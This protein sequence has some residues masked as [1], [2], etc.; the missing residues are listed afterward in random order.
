MGSASTLGD[1][2]NGLG[3]RGELNE[4]AFHSVAKYHAVLRHLR[5]ERQRRVFSDLSKADGAG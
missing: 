1:A 2:D 5:D 3:S 4:V